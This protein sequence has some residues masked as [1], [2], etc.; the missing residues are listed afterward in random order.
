MRVA[1][2]YPSCKTARASMATA[3]T[4][5]YASEEIEAGHDVYTTQMCMLNHVKDYDLICIVDGPDDVIEIANNHDG[6]YSCDR[7]QR[8]LRR[9][10]NF[11]HLWENGEF[12]R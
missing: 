11:F 2:F 5:W 7:T 8:V 3:Y 9:S 12:D 6:T 1:K 10:N 4:Y